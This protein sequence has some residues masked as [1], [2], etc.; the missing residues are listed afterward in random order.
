MTPNERG[1]TPD[2]SRG[3]VDTPAFQ[4][5]DCCQ[6]ANPGDAAHFAE[7]DVKNERETR[8]QL[9]QER[10]RLRERVAQLTAQP[11]AGRDPDQ[12]RLLA[13]LINVSRAVLEPQGPDEALDVLAREIVETG[14]LRSLMVALVDHATG[15]VRVVQSLSHDMDGRF[16]TANEQAI[17]LTYDLSDENVT[18]E[19]ARTGKMIVVDEFDERFDGRLDTVEGR[20]GKV[21]I[22]IPLVYQDR[23]IAVLA[24]GCE[25]RD[26]ADT[27]S[28][29]D[30]IRPLLDL[31]AIALDHALLRSRLQ[32]QVDIQTTALRATVRQLKKEVQ[33]RRLAEKV[34]RKETERAQHYLDVAGVMLLALDRDGRIKMINRKGCSII[35]STQQDL[36]NADWFGRF[37]PEGDRQT[38]RQV[39]KALMSGELD[40]AENYEN[41]IVTASGDT[42][43]IAWHNTVLRDESG[44]ITGTLSSGEDV[45]ERRQSEQRLRESEER[46]RL[47][48]QTNPDAVLL[49]DA[50]TRKIVDANP[51]A[52]ALYGYDR[53]DL[54]G[55]DV[56]AISDEP[57][58]TTSSIGD[59]LNVGRNQIALRYHK[60]KDGTRF[61]SEIS[62]STF[63]QGGQRVI[64]GIV[65]DNTERK[66]AEEALKESEERYRYLFENAGQGIAVAQD[67]YLRLVNPKL[68]EISGYSMEELRSRPFPSFVHEDDRELVVNR[69]EKRMKGEYVPPAYSFRIVHKNGSTRWLEI[70]SVFT[71]WD[72]RTATLNF[73][74]DVSDRKEAEEALDRRERLYRR[75]IELLDAVPYYR[76]YASNRFDFVGEGIKGLTGY[77]PEEFTPEVWDSIILEIDRYESGAANDRGLAQ[78]DEWRGDIHIR[79]R[80]GEER[81]LADASVSIGNDE[82]NRVMD[83]GI[84]QDIT[85]RKR[86]EQE[87]VRL[88][89]LRAVGELSA[90]VSHN[91][92]NILTSVLGPAQLI[93]QQ[94]GDP[95]IVRDADDIITATMRAADLV[96]QLHAST[97]L[98]DGE[99]AEPVD[100]SGTVRQAIRTSRPRWKDQ[101]GARGITVDLVEQLGSSS[102]VRG[103][104]TGLYD[105]VVN[106]ILNAVD[107]LPQGG[108]ITVATA[109][110]GDMAE[111]RISDT[112]IGMDEE[113]RRKVFEPFFTTKANVG[114]GLGLATVHGT[115]TRWGGTISVDS[116]QRHGSCFTIHLPVCEAIAPEPEM[117]VDEAVDQPGRLLIVDDDAFVSSFLVRLLSDHHKVEVATNADE[118]QGLFAPGQFD[119]ALVDL[120]LEGQPGDVLAAQLRQAD[121]AVS[122]IMITGWELAEED[123]RRALFDFAVKKPFGDLKQFRATIGRAIALRKERAGDGGET[124]S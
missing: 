57:E 71:V 85:A 10:D 112:G 1:R 28:R 15:Q 25:V 65:R 76:D 111:L 86:T 63:I 43:T 42:R 77:G 67:G 7:T 101:P 46:Y 93:K 90:G 4:R 61:P 21:A 8:A 50:E 34:V 24:T 98:W 54:L 70:S 80:D 13:G 60:R 74:S 108:T 56:T 116:E 120:G 38:V 99:K 30:A 33:E 23:A 32:A 124:G 122:L 83:L 88:E 29:V 49:I 9:I 3:S 55:L 97:R 20:R 121:R 94:T 95:H 35:G 84:L 92:N 91:L 62:A 79:T 123:P 66:L 37:V 107:A 18:A 44:A 104:V 113:T 31:V 119:V 103:T 47:L 12:G 82:S 6:N 36:L 45:T 51:A 87:L 110:S 5:V 39:Y 11:V 81:W 106:L 27:L 117:S 41:R 100:L 48:F 52:D 102:P 22:F 16:E 96:H 115:V 89:R 105:I 68:S 2:G 53:E 19:V 73:L 17:G 59:T 118:A 40:S 58:V 109:E 114:T 64:C 78:T 14:L 69:H 72:G 75:S 26:K